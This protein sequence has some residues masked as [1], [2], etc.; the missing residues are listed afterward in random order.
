MLFKETRTYQMMKGSTS[1]STY[2]LPF[3]VD[4]GVL[5]DLSNKDF[6]IAD[7]IRS[8]RSKLAHIGNIDYVLDIDSAIRRKVEGRIGLNLLRIEYI[9]VAPSNLEEA[10]LDIESREDFVEWLVY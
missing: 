2:V 3:H 1:E 5:I 7:Q 9:Y 8:Y 6:L 4:T 10:T